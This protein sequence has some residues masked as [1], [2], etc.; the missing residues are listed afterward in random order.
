[1]QFKNVNAYLWSFCKLLSIALLKFFK[2]WCFAKIS[3]I[4]NCYSSGGLTNEIVPDAGPWQVR[5][6]GATVVVMEGVVRKLQCLLGG[7]TPQ[8]AVHAR[9]AWLPVLVRT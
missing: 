5:G 6:R 9:V 2:M 1:M 3:N 4:N 8:V 7:V